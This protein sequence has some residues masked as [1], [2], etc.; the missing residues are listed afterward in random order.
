MDV[1]RFAVLGLATG[2]IYGLLS[3]GLVVIYR[4]SGVLNFAHGAMALVGAYTYYELTVGQGWSTVVAAVAAVL[5]CGAVGALVHVVVL[6]PLRRAAALSRVIATLGLV[7]VIQSSAFLL[8]G[9]NSLVVPSLFPVDPVE[10]GGLSIG[11]DRLSIILVCLVVSGGLAA[12]YRFTSFGRV[13]AAVAEHE[14]TAASLGHSPDLVASTNWA[15]GSALAGLAGVLISPLILLEPV[16]LVLLVIPAMASGLFGQFRSFPAALVAALVLG[17][18]QSEIQRFVSA[19]GWATAVPFLAVIAVLVVRGRSLPLRSFVLERLPAVGNG[20]PPWLWVALFGL[21]LCLVSLFAD[22]DWATAITTTAAMAVICLSVVVITGYAGQLSLAQFVLAGIG[23]L[24]AA[25][26]SPHV[27]FLVALGVGAVVTAVF[28]GIVGLPALRTRGVTLAVVSLGLASAVAAVVLNNAALNGSTSAASGLV[29]ESVDVFG[30]D[31]DPIVHPERYAVLAVLVLLLLS[32][33]V[34]NLRRGVTGRQLLAVRSNERAAASL[35]INVAYTKT[36]A[37]VLASGIAAVGGI[38][39][40]FMLPTVTVG[41]FDVFTCLL[42]VAVTV[43]GGVGNIPGA[44]IGALLTAG[45]VVSQLLSGLTAINDYLPLV[46]GLVLVLNLVVSPDGLFEFNRRLLAEKLPRP[47]RRGAGRVASLSEETGEPIRV[48]P[49]PLQVSGVSV[50]FGG[51]RAVRDV[52]L[53][54][55]PGE[56]HGLIGP[57]GAGKTTLID[58]VTGF[59]RSQGEVTLGGRVVTGWSPRSR[60]RAG[61]A[62]SFQSLELFTDLDIAENLAVAEDTSRRFRGVTDLFRPGQVRLG[63]AASAALRHLQLDQLIGRKPSEI[64]FGQRKAVAIARSIARMPSVLLL[65]EPAAGLDDREAADLA[66]LI[67]EL[68]D[69]WGIGVLLV[70]HKVDMIMAISDRVTVLQN[71]AVLA[72]GTPEEVA[73]NP[74]IIDAYLGTATPVAATVER[75]EP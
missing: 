13:T 18:A 44:Y 51:V 72:A 38:L 22:P 58:A 50:S 6:R 31:L 14:T 45:G 61:L 9:H 11:A 20:R 48:E 3:Q 24:V 8:F 12:V 46:G 42:V 75:V 41:D 33:A 21:A 26:V 19:P 1:L 60:A 29:I 63:P 27:P 54:V 52:S 10:L 57:N 49:W 40:A 65:D 2:A 66:L 17:V 62:R 28:G 64:S 35:G 7:L 4:G 37:F 36:Y 32:L 68:A 15:V 34:A 67:R 39:L 71:G 25:H 59:V 70:E 69:L 16:A 74:A 43:V 47:V 5:L 23:A 73:G 53:E 30:L 55:R 56:V